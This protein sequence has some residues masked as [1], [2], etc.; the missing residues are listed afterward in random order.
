MV[1]L[2]S[3]P[4]SSEIE[5]SSENQIEVILFDSSPYVEQKL[6]WHYMQEE[7]KSL[8]KDTSKKMKVIKG[9]EYYKHVYK[10]GR[11]MFNL[12]LKDKVMFT[13]PKNKSRTIEC[14]TL[15]ITN[16]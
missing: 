3:T 7:P 8:E 13:M 10:L 16:R 15:E 2:N 4:S 14:M 9:S 1:E 12:Y 6:W 11:D 5:L